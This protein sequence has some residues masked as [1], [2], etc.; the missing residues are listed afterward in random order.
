[1]GEYG[2][3]HIVLRIA[4]QSAFFNRGFDM[5][6]AFCFGYWT[7]GPK[8]VVGYPYFDQCYGGSYSVVNSMVQNIH[9]GYF[10]TSMLPTICR[11]FPVHH[12]M[13]VFQLDHLSVIWNKQH[14]NTSFLPAVHHHLPRYSWYIG[15]LKKCS[16][17]TRCVMVYIHFHLFLIFVAIDHFETHMTSFAQDASVK[18]VELIDVTTVSPTKAGRKKKLP[19]MNLTRITSLYSHPWLF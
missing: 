18:L 11:Y 13:L 8:C 17:I 3:V 19:P 2:G 9:W 7:I 12:H 16:Q 15:W 4:S 14:E 1:M 5:C 6:F 10:L